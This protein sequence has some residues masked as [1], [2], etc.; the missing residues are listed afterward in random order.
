[1]ILVNKNNFSVQTVVKQHNSPSS[2]PQSVFYA[3]FKVCLVL[4]GD[5]VWKIEERSHWIRSGDIVLLSMGQKR[6]FTADGKNGFRLCAFSLTRN[7]FAGVHH[8]LY[9]QERAR[10]PEPV[11]RNSFLASVLKELYE[12]WKQG[13]HLRYELA[14]AKLTEFFLKAERAENYAFQPVSD[15]HRKMLEILDDIDTNLING[16]SLSSV[17]KKAGMTESSFSRHFS[18][19]NGI[20]FKQYVVEKKIQRAIGLLQSTNAKMIDIALDSGFDSI[21]GFYAAFKKITGTTPSRF[22]EFDI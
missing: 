3:V 16:V 20:S 22:C 12:D 10:K 8:F 1:M 15:A 2:S 14:S 7:A 21:S 5:A 13:A 18:A 19:I 4:E 6:Q 17:A 11:I 9:F